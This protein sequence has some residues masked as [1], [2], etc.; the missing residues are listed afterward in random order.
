MESKELRNILQILHYESFTDHHKLIASEE[1]VD[2]DHGNLEIW[3]EILILP[4]EL[5]QSLQR[6]QRIH[7]IPTISSQALERA[8]LR[9]DKKF[10]A[11]FSRFHFF[12]RLRI[13]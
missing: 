13:I 12:M 5:P 4:C 6:F 9:I 1:S 8:V 2:F 7:S 11:F 3:K 10:Q